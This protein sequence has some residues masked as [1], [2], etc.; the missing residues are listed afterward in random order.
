MLKDPPPGEDYT[1]EDMENYIKIMVKTHVLHQG[2]NPNNPYPKS[3]RSNK[4]I[5]LLGTIWENRK[6]YEGT[7]IVIMSSDPYALLERLDLLLA[8][9]KAGHTG[10]RNELVSICDKLKRQGVLDTDAYK[11]LN[12]IIKN[13]ST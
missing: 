3:S 8:S 11:K 7:G 5:K 12:S 1:E 4:W 9:Q 6:K 13:D 10:V 2:N